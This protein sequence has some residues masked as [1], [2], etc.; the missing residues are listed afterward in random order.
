[1]GIHFYFIYIIHII[2]NIDVAA[3]HSKLGS[4]FSFILLESQE[5][6]L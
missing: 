4:D 5:N 3:V 6:S 1:M 2:R